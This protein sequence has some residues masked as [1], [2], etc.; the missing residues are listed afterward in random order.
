MSESEINYLL[1]TKTL[2]H[3]EIRNVYI[4]W[5]T[6]KLNII[7]CRK[8]V[9]EVNW[10]YNIDTMKNRFVTDIDDITASCFKL[11]FN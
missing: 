8:S 4:N 7:L 10:N 1:Y 9:N 5:F 2:N 6:A 11:I 3:A